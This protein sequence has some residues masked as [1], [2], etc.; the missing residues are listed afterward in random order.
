[1][2]QLRRVVEFSSRIHTYLLTLYV[3]FALLFVLFLYYPI[4]DSLVKFISICQMAM[5]WTILLEGVW[6]LFAAIFASIYSKVLVIKPIL[7]TLLRLL[8]YFMISIFVDI[9]NTLITSGFQYGGV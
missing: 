6:I 4:D 5:G 1:M 9:V 3:F 7:L 8:I 2:L